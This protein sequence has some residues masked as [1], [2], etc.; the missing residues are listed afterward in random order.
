M[1]PANDNVRARRVPSLKQLFVQ[2]CAANLYQPMSTVS[3]E[4]SSPDLPN[5]CARMVRLV[6]AADAFHGWE[7]Q[8]YVIEA[9]RNDTLDYP[10]GQS[11]FTYKKMI[12]KLKG[13]DQ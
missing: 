1:S 13:K 4:G 9:R 11:G 5:D 3:L 2:W 8:R 12:E 7:E 10:L 6:N